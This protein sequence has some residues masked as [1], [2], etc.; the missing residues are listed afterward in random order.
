MLR[1]STSLTGTISLIRVHNLIGVALLSLASIAWSGKP[2]TA[3]AVASIS[4]GFV[5]IA[6]A[7]YA[8]NDLRDQ[9]IDRLNRSTRPLVSQ[10]VTPRIAYLVSAMGSLIGTLLMAKFGMIGI[11]AALVTVGALFLYSLGLKNNAGFV[12]N[13]MVAAC[14]AEIPFLVG[15]LTGDIGRMAPLVATN[16]GLMLMREIL[17]DLEDEYGDRAWKRQTLAAAPRTILDAIL[18]GSLAVAVVGETATAWM[19]TNWPLRVI[20][21]ALVPSILVVILCWKRDRPL[22]LHFTQRAVRIMAFIYVLTV[23]I[24]GW[25]G[26]VEGK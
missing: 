23:L 15:I 5:C 21:L 18:F 22:S 4:L 6:A 25:C 20:M 12:G 10:S 14:V 16:F 1:Y 3:S 17:K 26:A 19:I 8:W 7:G 9:P 24:A 2:W 11:V 13:L